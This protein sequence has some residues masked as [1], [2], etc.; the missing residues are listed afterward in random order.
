M[1]TPKLVTP[2]NAGPGHLEITLPLMSLSRAHKIAYTCHRAQRITHWMYTISDAITSGS[3]VL[4]LEKN[5]ISVSGSGVSLT[6]ADA[7]LSNDP[8]WGNVAGDI[9][10]VPGDTIAFASTG[11]GTGGSQNG[12]AML[13][14]EL[15]YQ[16]PE[17][18]IG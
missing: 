15:S 4:V 3:N 12:I 13:F 5:G 18:A 8:H 11:G 9:L 7:A 17:D 6:S 2:R 10:L 14:Y 1:P 16:S